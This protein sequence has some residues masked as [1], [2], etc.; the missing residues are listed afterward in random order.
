MK[1]TWLLFSFQGRVNRAPFWGYTA[2]SIGLMF[3]LAVLLRDQP[4][5]ATTA[6]NVLS[7]VLLWPALAVQVKRWH[8]RDKSAWFLLVNLIPLAGPL[9]VLIECGWLQGTTGVNRFGADPLG[10]SAGFP[11]TTDARV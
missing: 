6:I 1:L 4:E 5:T 3:M 2:V 10:G 7:I 11:I 8:D 9:W